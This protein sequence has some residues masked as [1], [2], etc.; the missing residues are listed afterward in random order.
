ML[1]D[2]FCGP[3]SHFRSKLAKWIIIL[4]ICFTSQERNIFFFCSRVVDLLHAACVQV[5]I[6][7]LMAKD[8]YTQ[9]VYIHACEK[10][11]KNYLKNKVGFFICS[12]LCERPIALKMIIAKLVRAFSTFP[13]F[14]T[15]NCV[16][17]LCTIV[18]YSNISHCDI[19]RLFLVNPTNR[20][21]SVVT[22]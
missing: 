18:E 9:R 2:W 3:G 21:V 1:Y 16:E 19:V 4:W 20:F 17:E 10:H 7:S 22:V 12:D 13:F 14:T 8:D 15:A 5:M 11:I 6:V